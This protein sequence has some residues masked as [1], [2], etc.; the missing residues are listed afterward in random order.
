[1][2]LYFDLP[3]MF[4]HRCIVIQVIPI[5]HVWNI[6]HGSI[7]QLIETPQGQLDMRITVKSPK[8]VSIALREVSLFLVFFFEFLLH[9]NPQD[10]LT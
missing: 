4:Y 2:L 1:M 6:Y 5:D 7:V 3:L 8:D 10:T 9:R